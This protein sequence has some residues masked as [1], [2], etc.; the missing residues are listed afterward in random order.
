METEK[1]VDALRT[2]PFKEVTLPPSVAVPALTEK[3]RLVF[4]TNLD[5]YMNAIENAIDSQNPER[6][7]LLGRLEEAKARRDVI[8]KPGGLCLTEDEVNF[9][10][11][12]WGSLTFEKIAKKFMTEV[13]PKFVADPQS[14]SGN[15]CV[16][17]MLDLLRLLDP[18][19]ASFKDGVRIFADAATEPNSLVNPFLLGSMV[20]D[21]IH[22]RGTVEFQ[23]HFLSDKQGSEELKDAF[24]ACFG[25]NDR[26]DFQRGIDITLNELHTGATGFSIN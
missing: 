15:K 6:T 10:Y 23:F 12:E 25:E 13:F 9:I 21:A 26:N 24:L 22:R 5:L 11:D 3:M 8:F 14:S 19:I 2:L 4:D 17:Y 16:G 18:K 7:A 20:D 1:G